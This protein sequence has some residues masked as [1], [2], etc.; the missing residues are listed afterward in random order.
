ME[1]A[2]TRSAASGFANGLAPA[3]GAA[4]GARESAAGIAASDRGEATAQVVILTPLLLLLVFLGIQAALFFHAANVATAAAAAGADAGSR[5]GGT[6]HAAIQAAD[7][8]LAELGAADRGST[9]AE[10][11]SA[12]VSVSVVVSVSRVL[13]FFPGSVTRTAVEPRERFLPEPER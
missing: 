9:V 10:L 5:L 2:E 8:S 4:G 13:P 6:E 1:E 11:T 7:Q 12:T 3:P